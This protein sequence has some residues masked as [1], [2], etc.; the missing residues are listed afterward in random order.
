MLKLNDV[1]M[2]LTVTQSNKRNKESSSSRSA[3]SQAADN[4]KFATQNTGAKLRF[5]TVLATSDGVF[6]VVVCH[7]FILI[8]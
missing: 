1:W 5:N 4:L 7:F 8:D 6:L 3:S 2:V